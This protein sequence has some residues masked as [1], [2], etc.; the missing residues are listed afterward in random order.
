MGCFGPVVEPF[1]ER[2]V[3]VNTLSTNPLRVRIDGVSGDSSRRVK[4][5]NVTQ[6]EGELNVKV[7]LTLREGT[8]TGAFSKEIDIDDSINIISFGEEHAVIWKRP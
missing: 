1:R 2:G 3:R 6:K 7:V 4:R 8:G 5:V